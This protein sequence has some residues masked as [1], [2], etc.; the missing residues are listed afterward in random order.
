MKD[1]PE[2]LRRIWEI[3]TSDEYVESR[4]ME[5]LPPSVFKIP[6]WLPDGRLNPV[7]RAELLRHLQ[8]FLQL[9]SRSTFFIGEQEDESLD[10]GQAKMSY[11][12]SAEVRLRGR[13]NIQTLVAGLSKDPRSP[14]LLA[15][16]ADDLTSLLKEALEWFAIAGRADDVQDPSQY[17]QP[18][19]DPHPQNQHFH[20]W[21]YLIDLVR[22]AFGALI[23][24][25]PSGARSLLERWK[26]IRFPLFRRLIIHAVTEWIPPL[27]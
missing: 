2:T 19:I 20:E 16:I 23:S 9:Q 26:T 13:D 8:P 1:I 15:D 17:Y 22:D 6:R 21:C 18:S 14:E 24:M 7:A 27:R 10:S 12:V 4:R 11:Y 3:I 5:S 25:N